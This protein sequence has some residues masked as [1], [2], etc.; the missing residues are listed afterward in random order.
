MAGFGER[1]SFAVL[2]T[3]HLLQPVFSENALLS[4]KHELPRFLSR[5]RRRS[6]KLCPD[7]GPVL[8]RMRPCPNLL[9]VVPRL[10]VREIF[11]ARY[12][13]HVIRGSHAPRFHQVPRTPAGTLGF[14]ALGDERL[15]DV[16]A[17]LS[18]LG[19]HAWVRF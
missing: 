2:T 9:E 16:I 3:F 19:I 6:S 18:V 14:D 7:L 10:H 1:H 4:R 12:A 5:D 13:C 8:I 15:P 11:V 17:Q